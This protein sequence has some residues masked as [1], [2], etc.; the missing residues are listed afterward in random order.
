MVILDSRIFLVINTT[1]YNEDGIASY[2]SVR[3]IQGCKSMGWCDVE[4]YTHYQSGRPMAIDEMSVGDI[5]VAGDYNG[6]YLMRIA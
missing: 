4:H 6:A 5:I 2:D 1:D 3:G